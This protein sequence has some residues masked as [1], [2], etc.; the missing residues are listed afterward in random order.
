MGIP[1][2]LSQRLW[3]CCK[4]LRD[5]GLSSVDYLSQITILLFLKMVAGRIDIT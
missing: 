1:D 4:Y 2:Q 5:D 3:G